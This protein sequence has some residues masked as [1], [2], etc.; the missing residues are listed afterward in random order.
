MVCITETLEGGLPETDSRMYRYK[1]TVVKYVFTNHTIFLLAYNHSAK[2][3]A[4]CDI[5]AF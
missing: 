3:A 2:Q 4:A 1:I 5:N